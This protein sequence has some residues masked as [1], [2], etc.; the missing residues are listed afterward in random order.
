MKDNNLLDIVIEFAAQCLNIAFE[1]A[2][3]DAN[4]NNRVFSPQNWSKAKGSLKDIRFAVKNQY[5]S[6]K[7][8]KSTK[9]FLDSINNSLQIDKSDFESRWAAD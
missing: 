6:L 4:S 7:W 8:N 1:T 3:E 2:L 5:R 9:E